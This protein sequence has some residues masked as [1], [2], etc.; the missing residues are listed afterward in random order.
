MQ[1]GQT[2]IFI[3]IGILVFLLIAGGAYLLGRQ[4]LSDTSS[5]GNNKACTQEAKLCPDG[6]AVGRTGPNCEFAACPVEKADETTEVY[7]HQFKRD[8]CPSTCGVGSS[9]PMCLDI[10]CHAKDAHILNETKVCAQVIT[11]AKN[12]QTGQ[13]E[14]FTSSCIPEGWVVDRVNCKTDL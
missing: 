12:P 11:P 1:K 7:C 13:C 9:C 4:S 8:N 14:T 6:S 3:L 10:G 5:A 2:G